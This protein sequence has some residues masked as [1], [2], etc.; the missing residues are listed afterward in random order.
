M[1]CLVVDTEYN[2]QLWHAHVKLSPVS[3]ISYCPIFFVCSHWS[4]PEFNSPVRLEVLKGYNCHANQVDHPHWRRP[5]G[6]YSITREGLWGSPLSVQGEQNDGVWVCGCVHVCVCVVCVA[7]YPGLLDP[8]FVACS[9][10]AGE[11]L[12]KLSHMV[13]CTWMCGRVAP[14]RKNASKR[15]HYQS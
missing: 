9:T 10:N 5:L 2:F 7:L 1:Q 6:V 12:V 8:A 14:S 3:T 11:G 15:V 4:T 13:W